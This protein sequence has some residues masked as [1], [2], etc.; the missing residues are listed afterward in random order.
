MKKY[1]KFLVERLE[2]K[3]IDYI[4]T[5]IFYLEKNTNYIYA[6]YN[7]EFKVLKTNL[8]Y[9][10]ILYLMV[11]IDNSDERK[12]I[13]FNFT[14]VGLYSID[15]WEE[16][17]FNLKNGPIYN[18]PTWEMRVYS[19]I[20]QVL[21][22]IV[23]FVEGDFLL[24]EKINV[25]VDSD[26][27]EQ[28][29][30][31]DDDYGD[32]YNKNK[33]EQDNINRSPS[34]KVESKINDLENIDIDIFE[35]IKL[36]TLQVA[37]NEKTT[38]FIL[39]GL[40]GLG[41]TFDV[42]NTLDEL[43]KKYPYFS[44]QYF[45]GNSTPAGLYE[46]LFQYRKTLIVLDDMDDALSN[47]ETADMLKSVLD[48]GEKRVLDRRIK[49]YFDAV[50][51]T[52]R[53]IENIYKETGKLPNRFEFRGSIIFITN[54]KES[55][56]DPA[57]Y[58]RTLSLDV[59]L[60]RDEIIER[61]NKIMPKMLPNISIEKKRETFDVMSQLFN[62][63][64]EKAPLNLR[65]FYHCLNLRISNDVASDYIDENGETIPLWKLLMK[66]FLVR[67]TKIKD[68]SKKK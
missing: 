14:N 47:K 44:Y 48:T 43:V 21:D 60:E 63:Y 67:T 26:F 20:I 61:I 25:V 8:K 27:I 66:K 13:R 41:K 55:D 64:V 19:S 6:K 68:V 45:K 2:Q 29:D 53:E 3:K 40:P 56:F 39:S 18:K 22:D 38:S 65:T 12:A 1:D 7:E 11:N 10:S 50:G 15:M 34:E 62:I 9:D 58:T 59:V 37:M 23:D 54:L 4:N 35:A 28:Y 42:T 31:D 52:D 30:D 24:N 17:N 32:D 5:I 49:G 46:L 51:L 16:L 36:N 33:S 57:V